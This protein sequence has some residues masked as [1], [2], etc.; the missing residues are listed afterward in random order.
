MARV[1]VGRTLVRAPKRRTFW[2]GNFGAFVVT[3]GGVSTANVVPEAT[4]ENTPNPTIIRV[5][6]EI[7]VVATVAGTAGD[8]ALCGLGI[9]LQGARAIA[10]GV[11]G[12]PVPIGQIGSSWLFHRMVLL[13]SAVVPV[14]DEEQVAARFEVDSKAMRKCQLN[15]GFQLMVQNSVISGTMS[16]EV[17]WALRVLFKAS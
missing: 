1:S 16:F 14:Q 6:G 10:A 7:L 12:M 9:M 4:L 11:G 5:R 13:R 2:E 15:Q 3:T 17:I 8:S